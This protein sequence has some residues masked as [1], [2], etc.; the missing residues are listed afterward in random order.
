MV[1]QGSL[2]NL[3]KAKEDLLCHVLKTWGTGIKGWKDVIRG[4]ALA[5]AGLPAFLPATSATC[6]EALGEGGKRGR[7][8]LVSLP[9]VTAKTSSC[10]II[11]SGVGCAPK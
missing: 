5:L 8:T 2:H 9:L 11:S 7:G 3:F 4:Q 1:R 6:W 10:N